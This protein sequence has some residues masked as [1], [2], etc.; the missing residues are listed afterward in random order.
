MER[1]V[2]VMITA[3]HPQSPFAAAGLT[4]GDVVLSLEDAK[5]NTPQELLYRLSVLGE[6]ARRMTFLKEGSPREAVVKLTPAPDVPDRQVTRVTEDVVLRGSVLARVNPAVIAELNLPVRAE[7]VVV[8]ESSDF[9]MNIGLQAGDI[10][11]AIN[12]RAVA[13]P[14]DALA[15]AQEPSRRWQIDLI[16]GGKPKRVRF[17][18]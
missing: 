13:T 11:V 15:A 16:R 17:R 4:E 5:V 14:A 1:P 12:G 7:G 6:G 18:L 10:L 9:A 2:G 3:L 8:L